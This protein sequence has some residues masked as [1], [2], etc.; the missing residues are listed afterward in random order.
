V[1]NKQME[2]RPVVEWTGRD[3]LVCEGKKAEEML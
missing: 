2:N 3:Q 1:E